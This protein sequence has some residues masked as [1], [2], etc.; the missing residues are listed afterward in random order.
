MDENKIS[1]RKTSKGYII[2]V[3]GHKLT[4]ADVVRTTV[5]AEATSS[6]MFLACVVTKRPDTNSMRHGLIFEGW[7]KTRAEA[8]RNAIA[9]YVS[10]VRA[11]GAKVSAGM[12]VRRANDGI[13]GDVR[14]IESSLFGNPM[15][16]IDWSDGTSSEISPK[17]VI[18]WEVN[19][20]ETHDVAL[21]MNANLDPAEIAAKH[22]IKVG[23][24][25]TDGHDVMDVVRV[26]MTNNGEVRLRVAFASGHTVVASLSEV[27]P[28]PFN[29]VDHAW[30]TAL[31]SP[32]FLA[33]A[34][35][36]MDGNPFSRALAAGK[37]SVEGVCTDCMVT[38]V[39]GDPSGNSE[40]WNEAE[41][42]RVNTEYEATHGH[43][44]ENKWFTDC[45]HAGERC[46]EDADCDCYQRGFSTSRCGMCGTPLHGDREDFLFILRSDLI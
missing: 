22:G 41:Y 9:A 10:D 30:E 1:T 40:D 35:K 39:N 16:T 38:N 11:Y 3:N 31:D 5:T 25:V 14:E 17:Y 34:T 37:F 28:N 29:D 13:N 18:A 2:I 20:D 26:F 33:A 46:P 23:T 32:E 24:R 43:P 45:A 4:L 15:L 36:H 44:H 12:R 8:A 42:D 27:S 7:G 6:G 21:T 19:M